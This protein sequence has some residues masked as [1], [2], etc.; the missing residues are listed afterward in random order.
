MLNINYKINIFIFILLV[1]VFVFVCCAT[2]AWIQ[3]LCDWK[4][5]NV[6]FH[7]QT[8]FQSPF[9]WV[10]VTTERTELWLLL[11]FHFNSK[12]WIC[13]K[14]KN[15]NVAFYSSS[16][17][18]YITSF[19]SHEILLMFSLLLDMSRCSNGNWNCS[20]GFEGTGM[21][22]N[23]LQRHFQYYSHLPLAA[24]QSFQ[25]KVFQLPVSTA[26]RCPCPCPCPVS[27]LSSLP[28]GIARL[29]SSS[30][31]GHHLRPRLTHPVPAPRRPHPHPPAQQA[32]SSTHPAPS[33][34]PSPS[35]SPTLPPA[36]TAS[37]R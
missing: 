4:Q 18:S 15:W 27:D 21:K 20:R 32:A 8:I 34:S 1:F 11:S 22:S 6:Y 24:S 29:R 7:F 17:N 12:L 30:L 26:S 14:Q 37:W 3:M 19:S 23:S 9:G 2:S 31:L 33:P 13:W 16:A 28:V 35:P 36:M 5:W 25:W 10:T